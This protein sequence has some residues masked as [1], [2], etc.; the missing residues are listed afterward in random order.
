M[1]NVAYLSINIYCMY[2]EN[3]KPLNV[4]YTVKI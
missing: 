2:I 3:K 1:L 4:T